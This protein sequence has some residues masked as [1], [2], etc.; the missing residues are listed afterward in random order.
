[1]T[2]QNKEQML[3]EM[4]EMKRVLQQL[5]QK[6]QLKGKSFN[7]NESGV[8]IDYHFDYTAVWRLI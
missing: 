6:T 8:A 5:T 4:S 1:M 2:V 3:K 7:L